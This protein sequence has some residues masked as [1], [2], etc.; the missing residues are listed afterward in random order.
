MKNFKILKEVAVDDCQS[1]PLVKNR[2]DIKDG[3]YIYRW[4]C[5]YDGESKELPEG[6]KGIWEHCPVKE[7]E[8]VEL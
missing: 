8:V 4:F 1:C 2:M 3:S 7:N 6:M 5:T